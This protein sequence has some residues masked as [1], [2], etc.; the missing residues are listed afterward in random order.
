MEDEAS[1]SV[2]LVG[3]GYDAEAN[4]P[5]DNTLSVKQIIFD[6]TQPLGW[7]MLADGQTWTWNVTGSTA[8]T[9]IGA[10]DTAQSSTFADGNG[11]AYA[12]TISG[13]TPSAVVWDAT[14]VPR[15]EYQGSE[16]VG[17]VQNWQVSDGI[18]YFGPTGG[19]STLGQIV[20]PGGGGTATT[21]DTTSAAGVTAWTVVG[22]LIFY[23]D[24]SGTFNFNPTTSATT[25]YG[26]TSISIVAVTK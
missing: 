11:N 7:Q 8:A 4:T 26:D 1:N 25:S 22:G 16:L 14:A 15:T 2:Y 20:L 13:G 6:D 10:D 5:V 21:A 23:T 24:A 18:L 3:F 9:H 12:F 19:S 17:G